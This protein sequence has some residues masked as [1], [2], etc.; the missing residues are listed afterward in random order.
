M[1]TAGAKA[2]N[3]VVASAFSWVSASNLTL[4]AYQSITINRSVA[5]DGTGGLSIATDDGG[6]VGT[7]SFGA[8]GNVTFLSTANSLMINGV[9][10]TLV[11]DVATLVSGISANPSGNFA[12]ANSYDAAGNH[13]IIA[14][15]FS[16]NFEGLGNSISNLTLTSSANSMGLFAGVTASG[17]IK[18][19]RLRK[20]V[21]SDAFTAG[22][23]VGVNFGL[24][25]GDSTTGTIGGGEAAGGGLVGANYGSVVNCYSSV[26]ITGGSKYGYFGGLVGFNEANSVVGNS[27]ATGSVVVVGGHD[28]SYSGDAGGLAGLNYGAISN[29]FATGSV[30]AGRLSVGGQGGLGGLVGLNNTPANFGGTVTSSY[31]TGTVT[32]K[33][34]T[35]NGALMGV[36][37][38]PGDVSTS[39]WDITTSGIANLSQ[40]AG[41]LSNDPGITGLT[42]T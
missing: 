13:F 24:L 34:G 5:A 27:Y 6:T 28:N 22:V 20:A 10:Y 42:T 16:G 9:P 4:D 15:G 25:S 29:S 38:Y 26:K 3:I 30:R 14:N 21:G 33:S 11:G 8:N 7:L 23:L 12:L 19:I 2:S 35:T 1:T 17:T 32:L 40:G 37:D 41:N 36:D 39:Y 31:S 18:D